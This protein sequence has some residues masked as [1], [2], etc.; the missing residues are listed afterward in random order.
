MVSFRRAKEDVRR[1]FEALGL[2]YV[3]EG[4]RRIG[5][6]RTE[7]YHNEDTRTIGLN[8]ADLRKPYAAFHRAAYLLVHELGHEFALV[9]L[10][11][12]DKRALAPLFGDYDRPY[13]RAPRP[14]VAGA[15]FVSRYAMVH[16][17][18]DFTETFAVCLWKHWEPGPVERLLRG[19]SPLCRRKVAAVERLVRRE[20]RR[21][22]QRA[23]AG[24]RRV[25][26]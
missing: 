14:R 25:R 16:P 8:P 22:R 20:A 4:V 1:R 19:K 17:V 21:H 7:S 5:V 10:A 23:P 26:T 12:A 9:S 2:S 13:R 6:V 24:A 11:G 3:W 18:E 15:D